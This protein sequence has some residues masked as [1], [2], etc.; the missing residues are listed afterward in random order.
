MRMDSLDRG[1]EK[2]YESKA[3]PDQRVE[4]ILELGRDRR[5]GRIW[6]HRM[7]G[8]AAVLFIAFMGIH[9]HLEREG[10]TARVVAEIAMNHRKDL[11]VEVASD[12]FQVVQEKL[13]RLDFPILPARQ[14]LI[15]NYALVGGR[16]C[17]IQGGLAAQLKIRDK[18]SGEL[19]TLYI[20]PLTD[21]L[22][23]I[24]ELVE[25]LDGVQVRMWEENGR[26]FGLAGG[27]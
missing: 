21:E 11:G 27:G 26:F 14:G 25:E 17:S 7:A 5:G 3:L 4:A 2:Y 18:I 10:L 6:I 13:D 24:G 19:L 23:G 20:T 9:T 8:I 15:R 16:Y 22:E 1:I 12:Q